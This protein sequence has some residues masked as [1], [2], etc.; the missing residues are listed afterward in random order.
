M[1]KTGGHGLG[2]HGHGGHGYA[3]HENGLYRGPFL[4]LLV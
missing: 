4:E 3:G 1:T 2:G